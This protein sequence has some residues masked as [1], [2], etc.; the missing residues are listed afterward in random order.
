MKTSMHTANFAAEATEERIKILNKKQAELAQ[1]MGTLH[2]F[3]IP[4]EGALH[5]FQILILREMFFDFP[6]SK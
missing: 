6:C 3:Q 5:R 1:H 4:E 2:S